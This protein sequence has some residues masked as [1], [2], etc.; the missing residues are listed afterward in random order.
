MKI[1][2]ISFLNVCA[3]GKNR[4]LEI[5]SQYVAMEEFNTRSPPFTLFWLR[6]PVDFQ[7]KLDFIR[8]KFCVNLEVSV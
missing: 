2:K 1:N 6:N 7:R 3:F 4:K 5:Y 8:W